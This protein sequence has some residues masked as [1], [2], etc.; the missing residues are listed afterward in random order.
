M[1]TRILVEME[2]GVIQA[3]SATKNCFFVVKDYDLDG[4]PDEILPGTGVGISKSDAYVQVHRCFAEPWIAG[5]V[6]RIRAWLK[7]RARKER[8]AQKEA[9]G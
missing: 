8:K 9:Q 6:E 7:A 2:G 1:K 4:D 5:E 3:V